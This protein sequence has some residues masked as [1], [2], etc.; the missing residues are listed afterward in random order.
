[1]ELYLKP[2]TK[3]N[4]ETCIKLRT[5]EDQK[6]F[7]AANWY[8]ILQAHFEGSLYPTAIYHGDTMVGFLMYGRDP[9]TDRMEVCR[10]MV[11]KEH[12]GR[13]YGKEAMIKVMESIKKEYGIMD[14][15]TSVEPDNDHAKGL[16]KRL[17]FQETGEIMW[18][19]EVLKKTLGS[20]NSIA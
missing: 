11:D 16:Y 10:L 17:G 8:S 4:W 12:Q 7:V 9:E 18:G 2:I 6:D 13:G 15:Y 20:S 5:H 3:E 19:E 14:L 1:M